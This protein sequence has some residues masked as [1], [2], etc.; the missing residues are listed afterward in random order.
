MGREKD[1]ERKRGERKRRRV[2]SPLGVSVM[3]FPLAWLSRAMSE[4]VTYA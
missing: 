1:E 4:S 2:G 3:S